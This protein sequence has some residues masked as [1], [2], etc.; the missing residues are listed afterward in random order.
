M[1]GLIPRSAN[2]AR[3]AI[4]LVPIPQDTQIKALFV[5]VAPLTNNYIINRRLFV[6]HVPQRL[7]A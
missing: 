1:S 3:I 4:E 6:H 5:I 7:K 2:P